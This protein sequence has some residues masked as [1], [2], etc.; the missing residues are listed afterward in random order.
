MRACDLF[1]AMWQLS[2]SA[3][4]SAQIESMKT[5]SLSLCLTH[6]FFFPEWCLESHQDWSPEKPPGVLK[7]YSSIF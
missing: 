2:G 5:M 1:L 4:I 6:T 3:R 7:I